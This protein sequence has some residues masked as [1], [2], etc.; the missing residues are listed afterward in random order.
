VAD[1]PEY[2]RYRKE[3][4]ELGQRRA[5]ISDPAVLIAMRSHS[6]KS[7]SLIGLIAWSLLIGGCIKL[8]PNF[9]RP[10]AAVEEQW[11]DTGDPKIKSESA[12]YSN[13]WTVFNDPVLN[14][15][16]ET[17]YQQ[18]LPLRIAGIRI[19]EARARLGVAVGSL[20]PQSQG[21]SGSWTQF[22]ASTEATLGGLPPPSERSFNF[23]DVGLDAAWE[24]DFWCKFRRGIESSDA[25]LGA[26]VADYDNILVSLVG[27]VAATYTLIRTFQE[28]LE[29]ARENVKIQQ[30]SLQIAEARFRDGAVTELD[31]AQAK[32]L[33]RDTEALIP[34]LERG[35]R[36]A[37]NGLSVL[38]GMPPH[39]L[40]DVLEG[41]KPIPTAP[42]EVAVGIPAELLR[43]RPDI[44]SA[45]LRAAAQ[46]ARIGI[47]RADLF[48]AF[49]IAVNFGFTANDFTRLF[50][51][52]SYNGFGGPAFR[53]NLFNYGRLKNNVR[54]NDAA[55]QELVVN[56]QETVLRS[57]QEVE[58][59]IVAFL[60]SQEQERFLSDSVESAKRAVD[61]SLIQY[62]QGLVDYNL[63]L[64]SQRFL[65]GQ[66][67]D[68]AASRGDVVRNLIAIYKALGG[69]WEIRQGKDFVPD[70]TR[71]EMQ[72]RTDWGD[73]LFLEE[74]EPPPSLMPDF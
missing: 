12:D 23:W 25:E 68:L 57:A 41:V 1:S 74:I 9:V 5:S 65:V 11:I 10:P 26:S 19:L 43:R 22:K 13:W 2:G 72:E 69:S 27:E 30:R 39:D 61:L 14:S 53:W 54:A 37:Q 21:A 34:E 20:Y 71:K 33:L 59:A 16:V 48:P 66:Q 3:I 60:R 42:P 50:Q 32:T 64:D 4:E 56:Y 63:V 15:L 45:E 52:S 36:Q 6:L 24:L 67:D 17:A 62:R 49:S 35:L 8:G 7:I 31:V 73:L 40:R 18:N 55:F 28:R 29:F 44:R 47:A 70:E 58:D 38:L 51:G 46:S